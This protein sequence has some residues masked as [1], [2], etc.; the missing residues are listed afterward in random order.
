MVVEFVIAAGKKEQAR[1]WARVSDAA[2]ATSV[3]LAK[4]V[5]GPRPSGF[6]N[7]VLRRVATRD[8]DA[9]TELVAPRRDQDP[10]GYLSVRYSYPRWI[11]EA[12]V[13]SRTG[14]ARAPSLIN[15]PSAPTEKSPLTRLTPECTPLTLCTNRPLPTLFTISSKS[16]LPGIR[17]S[18]VS[19]SAVA[20]ATAT[21]IREERQQAHT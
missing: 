5:C 15:R 20:T 13:I 21:G 3:D 10:T 6:V 1:G 19:R 4:D 11:V 9:W 8:L 14:S 18:A 12:M 7:A 16:L 17:L 2:V